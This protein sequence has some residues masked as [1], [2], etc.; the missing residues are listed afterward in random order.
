MLAAFRVGPPGSEVD[1][2]ISES[3]EAPEAGFGVLPTA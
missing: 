3:T 2:V 1:E